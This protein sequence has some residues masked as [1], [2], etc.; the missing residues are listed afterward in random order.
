M[1]YDRRGMTG[2]PTPRTDFSRHRGIRRACAALRFGVLSA[3]LMTASVASA[4][5]WPRGLAPLP[6]LTAA[7]EQL[8]FPG[9]QPFGGSHKRLMRWGGPM[10]MV[11]HG[12]MA[13]SRLGMV[14]RELIE[15]SNL[16]GVQINVRLAGPGQRFSYPQLGRVR[17]WFG[18]RA[19]MAA[20]LRRAV[21]QRHRI[22]E[23]GLRGANCVAFYYASDSRTMDRGIIYNA[24]DTIQGA[25]TRCVHHE[26][27]HVM[28]LSG[29]TNRVP[30]IL[31]SGG[32]IQRPTLNDRI[33]LRALYD[34]R[35]RPGMSRGQAIPAARQIL[36]A[37]AARLGRDGNA[38]LS[39]GPAQ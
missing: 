7:F 25:G 14:R 5:D 1:G 2:P 31:V 10:T 9:V 20:T 13:R 38:A 28:G 3:G 26:L 36:A 6:E 27:M 15:I 22:R 37:L 33:V 19:G 30:T 18:P 23:A 4:G 12:P 8:V 21:G 29:H 39:L 16:T 11:L 35:L 24:T 32:R 34:P 17:M